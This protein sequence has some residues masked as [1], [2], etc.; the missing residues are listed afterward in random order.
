MTPKQKKLLRKLATE[1]G[2]TYAVDMNRLE[3]SKRISRILGKG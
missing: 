3:A 1:R 2:S